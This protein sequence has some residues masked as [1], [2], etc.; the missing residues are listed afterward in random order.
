MEKILYISVLFNSKVY[1]NIYVC[2]LLDLSQYIIEFVDIKL[3]EVLFFEQKIIYNYLLDSCFSCDEYR[4]WFL[5]CQKNIKVNVLYIIKLQ[6]EEINK[7][8]KLHTL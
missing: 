2:I 6:V 7:N 1:M 8:M 4:Y 5:F 3:F